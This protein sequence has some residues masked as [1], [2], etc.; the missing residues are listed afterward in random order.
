MGR[1]KLGRDQH[2]LKSNILALSISNPY[3]S[4]GAV[5]VRNELYGHSAAWI[6]SPTVGLPSKLPIQALDRF[7]LG[8]RVSSGLA[9]WANALRQVEGDSFRRF[10]HM[11][12]RTASPSPARWRG[13]MPVSISLSIPDLRE[14]TAL[15]GIDD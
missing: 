6:E 9:V 8:R 15:I 14:T 5:S 2:N 1:L 10:A 7:A 3:R 13:K 4:C 12:A 11:A